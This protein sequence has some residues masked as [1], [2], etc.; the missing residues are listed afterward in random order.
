MLAAHH[1]KWNVRVERGASDP[2]SREFAAE[3]ACVPT[4]RIVIPVTSGMWVF[5]LGETGRGPRYSALTATPAPDGQSEV[6]MGQRS[7]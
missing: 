5:L 3:T 1:Q 4:S 7:V 2:I 6:K